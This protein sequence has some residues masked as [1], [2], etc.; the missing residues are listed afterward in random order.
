MWNQ[1]KAFYENGIFYMGS[2]GMSRPYGFKPEI[3]DWR[4]G[5]EWNV[6]IPE[7]RATGSV[8]NPSAT[9]YPVLES[10]YGNVLL[11]SVTD[12]SN[13]VYYHIG[14]D[15]TTGEELWIKDDRVQGRLKVP[16][17]GIYAAFSFMTRTWTG[18]DINT[19]DF[20]WE[21]DPNEYPWGS[22]INYAPTFAYGKLYSGAWDGCVHAFDAKTGKEVWKFS[23]GTT[24]ET[25][26]NT[27][28]VWNGPI[29]GGGVVFVSTGEETPTQPLTRGNKV[30]AIDAET[31]QELWNM[32]GLM[33]LRA[34][35][36]GYLVGLNAYDYKAYCFGKG[37]SETTVTVSSKVLQKGSA[38]LIE[39]N[40][41]DQSPGQAGTPCVSKESMGP[42]M[43]YLHMQKPL[44]MDTVG[45]PVKLEAFGE[46]GSY[47][48]I[49]TVITDCYG[50]RKEWTPSDEG[51]YTV[52]AT[53]SGDES[54]GSSWT[55]TGILVE[56]PSTPVTPI[57]P[58][59]PEEPEEPIAPLISTE[60]AITIAVAIIA[61]IGVVAYLFLKRR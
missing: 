31:G 5:I 45:V 16:G 40:V 20:L 24:T 10:I 23:V 26:F 43:E 18:Y 41:I 46:D 28:P 47:V 32:S 34:I 42:W 11:A 35:A 33:S 59:E 25:V 48:D 6:T 44:P 21:S 19:G 57:E 1:T 56:P 54:Y 8:S 30:F 4:K 53:F 12:G 49:G 60:I 55:A 7:R 15:A 9:V 37:P 13:R 52:T 14:Y 38:V 2:E 50:F 58:E 17:E 51:I 29:I 3:F 39:G 61:I 22:Y 27:W 36:D